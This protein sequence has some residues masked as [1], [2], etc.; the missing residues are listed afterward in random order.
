[1]EETMTASPNPA[2][3]PDA[4][5]YAFDPEAEQLHLADGRRVS[6]GVIDSYAQRVERRGPVGLIP[7]GKPLTGGS[8]HS[9]QVTV[10]LPQ[11]VRDR[12]RALAAAEHMSVSRWIRNLVER[13][14]AEP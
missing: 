10:T 6:N 12:V 9:P 5:F 3:R 1:M 14:V 13:E 11:P 2:A 4:E 7:G 8:T